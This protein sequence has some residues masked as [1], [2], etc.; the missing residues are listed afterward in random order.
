MDDIIPALPGSRP[1][2]TFEP[3]PEPTVAPPTPPEEALTGSTE[4]VVRME[5]QMHGG[6]LKRSERVPALP[7]SRDDDDDDDGPG[8]TPVDKLIDLDSLEVVQLL[9]LRAKID[10]RLPTSKLQD[11]D[12]SEELVLQM[13]AIKALQ[14][15]VS[16]DR[17]V[18]ANQ[19][20]QV[21]NSL[22][23]ALVNLVKLQSDVYTSERF[24]RME[25]FLVDFL[26]S[27]GDMAK[28]RE[29]FERYEAIVMRYA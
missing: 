27:V 17:S 16:E 12:M 5:P 24:K 13:M 14:A 26:N 20:A 18:P 10:Q 4:V 28:R 21:A 8:R 1:A 29:L 15:D 19:R 6:K 9:T 22:S 3:E 11:V 2:P 7:G 23:A 25:Q